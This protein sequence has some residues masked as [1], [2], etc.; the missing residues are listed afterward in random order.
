MV[1]FKKRNNNIKKTKKYNTK[2]MF[3]D[4]K[5]KQEKMVQDLWKLKEDKKPK[6]RRNSLINR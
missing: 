6:M 4:L 3:K 5:E 2:H 1:K